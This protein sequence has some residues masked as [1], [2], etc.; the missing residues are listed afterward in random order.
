VGTLSA[1]SDISAR[2][3]AEQRL[4]EITA[5]LQRSNQSLQEFASV[6]S[7]DLQE[8]L[9]KI[10]AFGDRLQ[11]KYE[12]TLGSE[13]NDYVDRMQ[14]AAGRMQALINDLLLFSRVSSKAQPPQDVDLNELVREVESDLE[15]R[16]QATSGTLELA[17]MPTI[18][19]DPMQ[20]R[21]LFQNVI[22]N[23]LKFHRLD[24]PPVVTVSAQLMDG[25]DTEKVTRFC[26]LSIRDNGIGFDA[27]YAER[28]FEVFERLHSRTEF[29]GTGMGLAICRRIV[30]R[31]GGTIRAVSELGRGTTFIIDLP[32]ISNGEAAETINAHRDN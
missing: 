14:N 16:L 11:R 24:T 2:K 30:E 18:P 22:G 17:P 6:A 27:K 9:R 8:P 25:V 19:G 7:H 23:A 1:V 5:E 12:T 20:L 31:H 4:R 32:V 13:G 3:A 26:R 21:Q 29:E 10:Q 28:V 15:A